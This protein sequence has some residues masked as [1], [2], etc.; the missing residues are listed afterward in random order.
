MISSGSAA[1]NCAVSVSSKNPDSGVSLEARFLNVLERATSSI[2]Q[3]PDLLIA[4]S[5]GI[6][7]VVLLSL[8]AKLKT[9]NRCDVRA[10]YI[11]HGLQSESAAWAEHCAR[12]CKS[13]SVGFESIAVEVDLQS[14]LSPEAAARDARYGALKK[15]LHQ[16]E[17]LCTAHHA[18]DQAETLLL[19]LFRGAGVNGLAAMPEVCKF[20]VGYLLRPLL[21]TSQCEITTYAETH[22]LTWCEDPSNSDLRYDRNYLRHELL[23]GLEKRWPQV[24]QRIARSAAH[25]AE[26]LTLSSELAVLDLQSAGRA[27]TEKNQLSV[28][29][30]HSLGAVRRKNLVR[31]WVSAQG[32]Q[33]PS[34]V[35]LQQLL[36]D[37][38]EASSERHG[39]VSFGDAEV[40]RYQ[41]DLYIG[42]RG[43]FDL[44]PDFE[45]Q[46]LRSDAPLF[47]QELN[48]Q[49]DANSRN[50]L[51]P[52]IGKPLTVRN[53]RGGERWRPDPSGHSVS[54]KSLLQQHRV[55]PWLRSRILL[56]FHDDV[57]IDICGP[58][59][60][61]GDPPIV[62]QAFVIP[63]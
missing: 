49:L 19:Q 48:W 26:A 50:N 12:C 15:V 57:L 32:Y 46:W 33:T 30:L 21:Q 16:G 56:V 40:A 27:V 41:D 54:V 38:V 7:S 6:D 60:L 1:R 24:T 43:A 62:E 28:S 25:C 13:L 37:L 34:T 17:Y 31:H 5:G 3:P 35:Q 55:P 58:G 9:Q 63:G 8:T 22:G 45:Y 14:G 2:E 11:D 52:F 61:S 44:L 36:S 18:D 39:R 42:R 4:L 10:V 47:I 20:G 53:R 51:K 23:P 59:F 29:L